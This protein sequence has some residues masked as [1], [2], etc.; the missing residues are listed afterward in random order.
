MICNIINY[1]MLSNPFAYPGINITLFTWKMF[2][3]IDLASIYVLG[4]ISSRI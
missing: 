4:N 1:Y 3:S 2:I